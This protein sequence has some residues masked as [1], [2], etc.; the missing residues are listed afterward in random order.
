MVLAVEF[1]PALMSWAQQT[2][3]KQTLTIL[4]DALTRYKTEGGSIAALTAGAPIGDVLAA[5]QQPLTRGGMT[6]NVMQTGQ[7]YPSSY[8]NAG[9]SGSSYIFWRFNSY[10]GYLTGTVQQPS[11]LPYGDNVG[12]MSNNGTNPYPIQFFSGYVAA[13]NASGV[14]T[15]FNAT[16]YT[17]PASPSYTFWQCN[18][19]TDSTPTVTSIQNI[20]FQQ[21]Q[22]SVSYIDVTGMSGMTVFGHNQ[23]SVGLTTALIAATAQLYSRLI[24]AALI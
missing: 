23:G 16:N 12:Y 19:A 5:M 15:I 14:V 9:G 10:N 18:S 20:R 24:C 11:T 1:V 6:H 3:D 17:L 7:T 4:N 13:R 21:N 2:S 22:Q 8:S